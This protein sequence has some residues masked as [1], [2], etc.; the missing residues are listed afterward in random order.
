MSNKTEE[1]TDNRLRQARRDGQIAK[2]RDLTQALSGCIWPMILAGLFYPSFMVGVQ[3]L[4]NLLDY[5]GGHALRVDEI[6]QFGIR[7]LVWPTIGVCVAFAT[8]AV[9]IAVVSELLQTKG[10]LSVTPIVPKFEKLNPISQIKNIFSLRTVVELIKGLVKVI[11]ISGI[12]IAL[13][14]LK[15]GEIWGAV[16]LDMPFALLILSSLMLILGT[17]SQAFAAVLAVVDVL[18]QKYEYRKGLRMTKDEV[19]RDY[20]QQEGDPMIKGERRRLHQEMAG[21]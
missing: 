3:I 13:I 20:K 16:R 1:P 10:L 2:S 19:K 18:Y 15:F 17:A 14:W 5:V 21:R 7:L 9:V 6:Q 12:T 11:V 8:T 4:K